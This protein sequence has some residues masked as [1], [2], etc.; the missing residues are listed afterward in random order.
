MSDDELIVTDKD[1]A[2]RTRGN[3][4]SDV[5]QRFSGIE[6]ILLLMIAG[7][8]FWLFYAT[9]PVP[10]Y[11]NETQT[12]LYE[13]TTAKVPPRGITATEASI[14]AGLVLVFVFLAVRDATDRPLTLRQSAK[15]AT[16]EIEYLQKKY[17]NSDFEG[18]VV[19]GGYTTIN[20]R[21]R[22]GNNHL[23]YNVHGITIQTQGSPKHYA[24]SIKPTSPMK[25]YVQKI[26][27]RPIPLDER[28]TCVWCGGKYTDIA[29]IDSPDVSMLKRLKSSIGSKK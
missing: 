24:V 5:L 1:L 26:S 9:Q 12:F 8:F 10:N 27:R 11:N 21:D 22:D 28:D 15:I 4:F 25:G 14:G 18:K 7:Y 29:Y 2:D 23:K 17:R 13:R 20:Y 6:L 19:P 16:E 3:L